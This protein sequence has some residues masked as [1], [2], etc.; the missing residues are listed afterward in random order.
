MRSSA[1][2]VYLPRFYPPSLSPEAAWRRVE[3]T[4]GEGIRSANFEKAREAR[5]SRAESD[6]SPRSADLL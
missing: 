1:N 5:A 2:S 4:G 3:T 6:L